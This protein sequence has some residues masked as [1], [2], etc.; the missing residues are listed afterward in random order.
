MRLLVKIQGISKRDTLFIVQNKIILRQNCRKD[1]IYQILI[2]NV[3]NFPTQVCRE[4]RNE[5]HSIQRLRQYNIQFFSHSFWV[6]WYTCIRFLND[7]CRNSSDEIDILDYC[8]ILMKTYLF[9]NARK[10]VTVVF[11]L[12]ISFRVSH[13]RWLLQMR[14][15]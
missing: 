14:C 3:R 8:G 11:V 5:I 9:F 6:M 10:A 1:L 2:D 7:C 13:R 12:K 15:S 4:S